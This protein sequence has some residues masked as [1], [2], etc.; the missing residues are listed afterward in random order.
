MYQLV[1]RWVANALS[2]SL[3]NVS[4]EYTKTMSTQ[5]MSPDFLLLAR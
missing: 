4:E 5:L 3:E 2:K 1:L